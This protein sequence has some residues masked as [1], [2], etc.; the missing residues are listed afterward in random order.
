[1]PNTIVAIL[2]DLAFHCH[3]AHLNETLRTR[4][5]SLTN[6]PETTFANS[7]HEPEVLK[8]ILFFLHVLGRQVS[9]KMYWPYL[10]DFSCIQEF[11][12]SGKCYRKCVEKQVRWFRSVVPWS[13]QMK[14]MI[15]ELMRFEVVRFSLAAREHLSEILK[16][17]MSADIKGNLRLAFRRLYRE[18]FGLKGIQ[19]GDMKRFNSA[20]PSPTV[21]TVCLLILSFSIS[22][23]PT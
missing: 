12:S 5:L 3:F 17:R 7:L 8:L 19:L 13:R 9:T 4:L 11:D 2:Q 16:T 22:S 18:R 14:S 6:D 1:M 21:N 20:V 15:A 10:P 23:L